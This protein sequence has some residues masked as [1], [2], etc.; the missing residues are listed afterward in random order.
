MSEKEKQQNIPVG[1][2]NGRQHQNTA[3]DDEISQNV[4][5]D[6]ISRKANLLL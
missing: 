6:T 1:T 5:L 3:K 2:W 4:R